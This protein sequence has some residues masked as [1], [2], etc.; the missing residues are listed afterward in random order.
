M[1]FGKWF[2]KKEKPVADAPAQGVPAASAAPA[3]AAPASAPP[4]AGAQ[5]EPAPK[6]GVFAR[7]KRGL[8]KTRQAL[9]AILPFGRK[10]DEEALEQIEAALIQADFGPVTAMALTDELREAY[11]GKEFSSDQVVPFLKQS[12]TRRLSQDTTIR[13]A[14]NGPTVIVV[15]GVNGTGKTTS[16]AKLTHRFKQEG[17]KVILAAADTFRAAAVEQLTIWSER[18]GVDIVTGRAESDPSAVVFD[19]MTRGKA[20]NFDVIIVDTAGRLHTDKNLMNQLSKMVRV[21]QKSIP[22][23]PHEVLQVLD[24]TTGQNA[25]QQAREFHRVMAV[26]GLVLTKLDGTARGGVIFPILEQ[27]GLPVKFVGVGEG[28]EDLQE[29]Q[30]QRFVD[31][32][33]ETTV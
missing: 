19:A 33:F 4:T 7:F 32:L 28:M 26:T 10:L 12:L 8:A 21:I 13:W 30:S 24:A 14:T 17:R 29:F 18:T 27:V 22:E 23:A 31:A 11:R 6:E 1:A 20:E 5:A 25:I 16:I 15:A 2:G 9:T 3:G